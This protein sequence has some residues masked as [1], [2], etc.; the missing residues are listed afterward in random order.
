MSF[1]ATTT[2]CPPNKNLP[3]SAPSIPLK[4][5]QYL[6]ISEHTAIVL[7]VFAATEVAP[8]IENSKV[9]ESQGQVEVNPASNTWTH[10]G[11][12]DDCANT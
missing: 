4:A 7:T 6:D 11:P 1:E 2:A 9:A 8:S 12:T 5:H 10:D 3:L